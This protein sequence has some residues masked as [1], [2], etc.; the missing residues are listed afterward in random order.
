[1][2][3]YSKDFLLPLSIGIAIG[4]GLSALCAGCKSCHQI[5]SNEDARYT[6]PDQPQRFALAKRTN[7]RRVLDIDSVYDPKSMVG[8]T[9]LVTGTDRL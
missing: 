1:M 5:C 8:K 2:S 6:I 9:V 3:Y 7:N 4:V